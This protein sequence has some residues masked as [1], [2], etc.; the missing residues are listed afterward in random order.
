[1]DIK[2]EYVLFLTGD[3]LLLFEDISNSQGKLVFWGSLYSISFA[4]F[5]KMEK[6]ANLDFYDNESTNEYHLRLSIDNIL[7]FRDTLVKKM[8]RLRVKV[9]ASKLIK[10]NNYKRLSQKE[11]NTMKIEINNEF[12]GGTNYFIF[13]VNN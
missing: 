1:M 6:K 12:V 4:K 13:F 8:K 11:I 10:G 7:L 9:E 3:A 5:N 2:A